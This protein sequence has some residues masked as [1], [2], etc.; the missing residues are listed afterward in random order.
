MR[1]K[2]AAKA[3]VRGE[4]KLFAGTAVVF[5][6]WSEPIYGAFK[7]LMLPGAFDDC[8]KGDPDVVATFDHDE[9]RMLGRTSSKTLRIKVDDKGLYVEVDRGAMSY[10]Q[11]LAE[12]MARG[13]IR[14]MSFT[15]EAT[16]DSWGHVDG[17]QCRTV[18]K[19]ELYE[20][21]FVTWPCYAA[22]EAELRSIM[23]TA[24]QLG[25]R[26]RRLDLAEKG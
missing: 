8:L 6:E 25:L 2:R 11:D 14:G 10:A 12:L 19:A 9:R 5:N 3:E 16:D 7:E 13:D 15:F 26:R 17:F 23:P 24:W 22:T 1:E 18:K 20:V 21:S 4:G